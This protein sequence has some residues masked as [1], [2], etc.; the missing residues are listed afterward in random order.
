MSNHS[1]S[2]QTAEKV[3]T[4]YFDDFYL[5]TYF[6]E[7]RKKEY[8]RLDKTNQTYLDFTGGNLYAISQLEKHKQILEENVFGN[9]HS[10]N[11]TSHKS[12]VLTEEARQKVIDFFNAHDY[13]CIFTANASASI[14]IIGE[15]YPFKDGQL[16]LLSDNHNSVNGMR[17]FCKKSKSCVTYAPIHYQD[18]RIDEIA[19]NQLLSENPQKTN[20]LFSFPAQSNVSGIKHDLNWIEKAQQKGWDVLLDA[21]A[22]VPTSRLDL[23][24]IQ[25]DFVSMSFYKIFGYPTGIG[26]LLIHKNK[27][28]K[29][30]KP[31]FAGGTVN[32]ASVLGNRHVLAHAHERFEDGTINYLD[33]PAIKIGLDYIEQIG[34]DKI[35]E[36]ISQL[37]QILLQELNKIEHNNGE[38]VVQVFG[39]TQK[40]YKGGTIIMNFADKNK[41][42][43]PFTQI[44]QVANQN[45][46]SIR[47]GCFCNPGLDEINSGLSL[48][49]MAKYFSSRDKD[50]E[51]LSKSDHYKIDFL[52][53]MRGAV[54]ISVGIATVQKDINVFLDFVRFFQNK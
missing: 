3:D 5:H 52:G 53:K 36:R 7:I 49:D 38:K 26:C 40:Q 9:P 31:W 15:S 44:E 37:T 42:N 13:Y 46:I 21:A 33:I 27:F 51:S 29:L 25:P 1:L 32:F 45:L 11:P 16:L 43:Y 22:F 30:N 23:S 14:K 12:T 19:L 2:T 24:K 8:S 4:T 20:K 6:E 28:D 47:T 50:F 39:S 35:S 41:N 34:I 54:R 18:L 17:E 10:S 48:E